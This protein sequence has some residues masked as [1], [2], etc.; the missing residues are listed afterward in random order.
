[1]PAQ[2][3]YPGIFRCPFCRSE[4]SGLDGGSLFCPE[5][6]VFHFRDGFYDF[7]QAQRVEELEAHWELNDSELPHSKIERAEIFLQPA[8][9]YIAEQTSPVHVLDVGCGDGVHLFVLKKMPAISSITALD[10]SE[11]AIKLAMRRNA[12]A[13]SASACYGLKGDMARLPFA[14][15]VFDVTFSYGALNYV[16]QY[17]EALREIV[18]VTKPG[19]LVGLWVYPR[20]KGLLW[21]AFRFMRFLIPRLPRFAQV[22]MADIL[23]H[24]LDF[25][26]TNSKI[27]LRNASWRQCREIILINLAPKFIVFFSKDELEKNM[28]VAGC[29]KHKIITTLPLSIWSLKN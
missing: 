19:G 17:A 29:H 18:R 13:E 24:F 12:G 1:M 9:E 28:S 25:F 21:S 8:L 4:L 14:D 5:H 26:P 23:V 27:S 2:N 15:S 6:N 7:T 11:A 16:E 3:R 10:I 20:G 22:L